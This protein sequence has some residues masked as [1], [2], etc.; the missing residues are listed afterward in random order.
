MQFG[1]YH[2]KIEEGNRVTIFKSNNKPLFCS[3]EFSF[4]DKET[5]ELERICDEI[6][7]NIDQLKFLKKKNKENDLTEDTIT[8]IFLQNVIEDLIYEFFE[9]K[10]D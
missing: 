3:T 9:N 2:Y 5:K 8:I 4:P 7:K 10:K 6:S 1:K